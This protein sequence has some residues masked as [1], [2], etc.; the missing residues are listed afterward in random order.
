VAGDIRALSGGRGQQARNRA[1][2]TQRPPLTPG[3]AALVAAA[4]RYDVLGFGASLIEIQKL[5]YFLQEAGEELNLRYQPHR[6]G[7]YADNLR[8]VLKAL[9]GHHLSGFGDGSKPTTEAEPIHVLNGAAEEANEAVAVNTEIGERLDRVL[10]LAEGYESPY[11]LE[12][13][14]TVHWTATR[15]VQDPHDLPAV[16]ERVRSWSRRK[17]RMFTVN[18]ITAAWMRLS[19]HDWI[20]VT[21]PA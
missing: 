15:E 20:G 17:S 5:M 14:A 12:L 16:I 1:V 9:E 10:K 7:P 21:Q 3:K 6:Y 8:H 11:G 4:D 18:H 13:L 19:D 2:S